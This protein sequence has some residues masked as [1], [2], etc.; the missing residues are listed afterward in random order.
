MYKYHTALTFETKTTIESALFSSLV[1]AYIGIIEERELNLDYSFWV[2]RAREYTTAYRAL[3]EKD[4]AYRVF[5]YAYKSAL[6]RARKRA[7]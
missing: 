1:D 7:K 4:V 3:E 5:Y 2:K 6:E